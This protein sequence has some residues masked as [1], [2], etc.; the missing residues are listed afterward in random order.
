MSNPA[1]YEERA[2]VGG[3]RPGVTCLIKGSEV[4]PPI[5]AQSCAG[6]WRSAPSDLQVRAL[7][8][9]LTVAAGR[10][11]LERLCVQAVRIRGAAPLVGRPAPGR[12]GLQGVEWAGASRLLRW[13][14]GHCA[15]YLPRQHLQVRHIK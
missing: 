9:I 7:E 8:P 3:P 13:G 2:H 12:V 11:L 1:E 4:R 10:L 15:G 14:L 6:Q 5:S